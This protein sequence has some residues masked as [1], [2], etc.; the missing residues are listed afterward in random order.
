[1]HN[2]NKSC[3]FALSKLNNNNK[4]RGQREKFC[5]KDML[6][7][8]SQE[9]KKAQ[10]LANEIMDLASTNRRNNSYFNIAFNKLGLVIGLLQKTNTF[11]AKIADT[12]DKTM[13]PFGFQVAN[14][15]SKQAWILASTVVELNI[16]L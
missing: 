6:T 5:K 2:S 9:Y 16:N 10:E 13:N 12:V 7:K 15:S 3:I 4:T 1:M 11:A 14:V 8:G